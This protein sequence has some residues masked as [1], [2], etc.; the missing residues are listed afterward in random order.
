MILIADYF[1]YQ[2][3]DKDYKKV[4]THIIGMKLWNI[5]EYNIFVPGTKGYL[6]KINGIDWDSPYITEGAKRYQTMLMEQKL[7][8]VVVP[9]EAPRLPKYFIIDVDFM[10]NFAW[11]DRVDEILKP[12]GGRRSKINKNIENNIFTF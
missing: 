12:I 7:N 10:V 9:P 2:L 6:F 1:I 4:P 11:N 8:Y 5:C 3:D